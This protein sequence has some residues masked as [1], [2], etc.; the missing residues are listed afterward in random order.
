MI[1]KNYR[2][3]GELRQSFNE[4][5]RKTFGIDFEDWYQNGFWSDRYNPYSVVE[6]G[7][8]VA[9]VSVNH[10]NFIRR[11][12]RQFFIQLGTV[13]TEESYRNRGLIRQIME[14]IDRDYEKKTDGFFLFANDSVLDF[15]PKFGFRPA[16]EYQYSCEIS[17]TPAAP[18]RS[19]APKLIEQIPMN[20]KTAWSLL[21]NAIRKSVPQGP[22]ELVDNSGLI[23]FYVTKYMREN[24][25]YHRELDAYVIAETD[26]P[27]LLIH[28]IFSPRPADI[29]QI[30]KSFGP[31]IH[32]AALGF[33]P[34]NCNGY[35][36]SPLKEEDCTL[37]LKGSGFHGFETDRLMFPV[38]SHA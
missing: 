18:E 16:E 8:V 30:V 15:Y 29:P 19:G 9:N 17:E 4:L 24:V 27:D 28:H 20:D 25:Y 1:V 34:E 37:F 13:M 33:T 3:N 23:L 14:E 5:A 7:R 32:R 22:F 6:N 38:L 26:G 10:M 36:L 12:E 21:A 11:G 35:T 2:N 31:D